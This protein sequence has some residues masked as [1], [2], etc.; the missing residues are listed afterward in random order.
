MTYVSHLIRP[1]NEDK[2]QAKKKKKDANS[3]P[4]NKKLSADATK[5]R[6]DDTIMYMNDNASW[7]KLPK[8][9]VI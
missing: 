5:R 8:I 9:T 7:F 3:A 6:K 2:Q 1:K 4:T